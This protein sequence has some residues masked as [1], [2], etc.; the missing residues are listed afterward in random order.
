MKNNFERKIKYDIKKLRIGVYSG[1]LAFGILFSSN[2]IVSLANQN[3]NIVMNDKNEDNFIEDL[4]PKAI[5]TK[6]GKEP[7]LEQYKSSIENLPDGAEVS[8]KTQANVQKE[9]NVFSVLIIKLGDKKVELNFPVIVEASE[10]SL[11]PNKEENDSEEVKPEKNKEDSNIEEI[12][13]EN[14]NKDSKFDNDKLKDEKK[15]NKI[16][17]LNPKDNKI[18]KSKPVEKKLPNLEFGNNE[19]YVKSSNK[20]LVFKTE[21]ELESFVELKVDGKVV[22][23]FNYYLED[24][25]TIITLKPSYLETLSLG[26]HKLEIVSSESNAFKGATVS[27]KFIVLEAQKTNSE[28]KKN[29]FEKNKSELKNMKN[30]NTSDMGIITYT[31]LSGFSIAGLYISKNR[32]K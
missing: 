5:T 27:T 3:P 29:K 8:I 15:E 25:S 22:E 30:P 24:G 9:D 11:S 16:N 4:V 26:E 6:V 21:A 2:N 19:V 1:I 17:V 31:L 18:D 13:P 28:N 12:K 10:E 7:T 14:K 23:K 20:N 32:K